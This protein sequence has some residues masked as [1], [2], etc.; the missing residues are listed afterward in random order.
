MKFEEKV[1]LESGTWLITAVML[2]FV[3][4]LPELLIIPALI[5]GGML[6]WKVYSNRKDLDLSDFLTEVILLLV[7]LAGYLMPELVFI[8]G[9][10][11][12]GEAISVGKKLN[13]A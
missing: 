11:A 2:I 6:A 12:L 8:A 1:T 9:G 13:G 5:V 3:A 4:L 7:I 10:Y